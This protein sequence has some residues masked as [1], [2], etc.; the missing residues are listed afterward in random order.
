ML[1][2][3][4]KIKCLQLEIPVDEVDGKKAIEL[5][6]TTKKDGTTLTEKGSVKIQTF[7]KNKYTITTIIFN[8]RKWSFCVGILKI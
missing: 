2:F 4:V 5:D 7:Y 1:K 8:P 3:L 6:K